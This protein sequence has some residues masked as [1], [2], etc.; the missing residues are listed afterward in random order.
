MNVGPFLPSTIVSTS[1]LII[2]PH[3]RTYQRIFFPVGTVAGSLSASLITQW[4]LFSSGEISPKS[5]I[6]Y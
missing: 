6:K 2:H 3:P 1:Q 4:R 5:E